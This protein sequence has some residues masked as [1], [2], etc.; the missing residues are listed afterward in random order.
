MPLSVDFPR[1]NSAAAGPA[2]MI[3]PGARIGGIHVPYPKAHYYVLLVIA[4]TIAG[5]WQSY[6]ST[7]TQGPWQFHAHAVAAS[8]WITLVATQSWTAHRRQFAWHGLAGKAS[9]LLFPFLIG[10]LSAIIDLTGKGYVAGDGAS[11]VMFGGAFLIG[12]MVA[13]AAYVTLYYRAL[14]Y[15]RKVWQ[16]SGYMLAT[17]LILWESPFSRVLIEV[18]P[19]LGIAGPQDLPHIL[20]SIEWANL[21]ALLF[22][23]IV[24]WRVGTRADPFVVAAVFIAAQMFAMGQLGDLSIVLAAL[25]SIGNLPSAVVVGAGFTIGALTSW[26]GW[27]AGKRPPVP[28]VEAAQPA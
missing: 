1:T 25:A 24:R 14:R 28:A 20:H 16:H 11:R 22:C 9:L 26:A 10:G 17:P 18:V 3:W 12:L 19:G 8:V 23:L 2:F 7:F 6:F 13:I 21:T 27:Q 15:R 4:V 5:F